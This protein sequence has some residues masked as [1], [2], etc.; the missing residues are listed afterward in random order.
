[1]YCRWPAPF[2]HGTAPDL[3]L[4][5]ALV[6]NDVESADE[7][8]RHSRWR[9]WLHLY[10]TFQTLTGMLL[11]TTERL[12]H[13]DYE[14]ITPAGTHAT[15]TQRTDATSQAWAS[16]LI[17]VLPEVKAGMQKL[18][19]ADVPPPDEVGYEHANDN[20][21]V[22]AEAEAAWLA[23]CPGGGVDRGL[24]GVR[25]HL[26]GTGLDRRAGPGGLGGHGAREAQHGGSP[27]MSRNPKVALSQDF[28][29]NLAK[30]PAAVRERC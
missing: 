20:G 30:L 12:R 27:P 16:L 14:S 10:N 17:G 19:E 26:A 24:D 11:A 29:L 21:D 13:H 8:T 15:G 23:G 3:Q 25:V 6:L 5:G 28:L 18:M 1:M 4:P 22:D 9:R 2:A 7:A